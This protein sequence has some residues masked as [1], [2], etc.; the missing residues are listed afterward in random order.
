MMNSKIESINQ[1]I[2]GI[3]NS[4]QGRSVTIEVRKHLTWPDIYRGLELFFEVNKLLNS[5]LGNSIGDGELLM[6]IEK[7]VSILG[8]FYKSYMGTLPFYVRGTK[9][10][11]MAIEQVVND[12]IAA[13]AIQICNSIDDHLTKKEFE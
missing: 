1:L 9:R 5:F 10:R 3:N 2:E 12:F 8:S 11:K 7:R 6:D 4:P 13:I